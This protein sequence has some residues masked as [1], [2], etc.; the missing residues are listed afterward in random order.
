LQLDLDAALLA[1]DD[2]LNKF[3]SAQQEENVINK[4]L[5]IADAAL[6]ARDAVG[7]AEQV[8]ADLNVVSQCNSF[9][10]LNDKYVTQ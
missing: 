5:G 1:K 7:A 3:N 10:Q 4:T 9:R 2:A 8:L 6:S